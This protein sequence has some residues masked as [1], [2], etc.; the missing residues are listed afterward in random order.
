MMARTSNLSKIIEEVLRWSSAA[1]IF[2]MALGLSLFLLL[3]PE[4][5][6]QGMQR[7]NRRCGFLSST[8]SAALSAS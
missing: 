3:G 7:K 2:V 4:S 5:V 1:S 8:C 6:F